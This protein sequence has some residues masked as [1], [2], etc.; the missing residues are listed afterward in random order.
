MG[1]HSTIPSLFDDCK[2]IS[3]TKLKAWGYLQICTQ[4]S[5]TITWSRNEEII[6]TIGFSILMGRDFGVFSFNYKCDSES[7]RY[8]VDIISQQSNLGNG[9]L[10][11]FVCPRT[12]KVCRKLHFAN[13]YFLHR[14]AFDNHMYESQTVSK[15]HRMLTK[16]LYRDLINEKYYDEMY[17]RHFKKY[18]NGKPTKR[19]LALLE[20]VGGLPSN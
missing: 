9:Q 3:I 11:F 15:T 6:S 14:T 7:I 19:Y 5:G 10:W 17:S 4:Q 2:T 12:G 13:K 20:K 18:Y 8:S 16:T 1:R